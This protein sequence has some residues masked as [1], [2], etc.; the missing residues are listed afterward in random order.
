MK[1]LANKFTFYLSILLY[2]VFNLR[3]KGDGAGGIE[4][5]ASLQA[6]AWQIAST[7]PYIAGFTYVVIAVL[8]Y[9]SDGAKVPWDRRIRLFLAFGILGGLVYAIWEYGGAIK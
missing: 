3:I 9:M 5:V 1:G 8:Q 4:T 6:T 2:L 7:A